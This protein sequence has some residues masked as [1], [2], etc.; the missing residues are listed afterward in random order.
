MRFAVELWF[1]VDDPCDSLGRTAVLGRCQ[2]T[3]WGL[4]RRANSVLLTLGNV[5]CNE[6]EGGNTVQQTANDPIA[7]VNDNPGFGLTY[8]D[9]GALSARPPRRCAPPSLARHKR[10]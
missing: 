9:M 6:L 7:A 8:G 1:A 2:W 5:A 3:R 10:G 4:C